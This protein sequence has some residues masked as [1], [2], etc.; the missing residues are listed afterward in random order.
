MPLS[1]LFFTELNRL[2]FRFSGRYTQECNDA[3]SGLLWANVSDLSTL[4]MTLER[5]PLPRDLSRLPEPF[6]DRRELQG[7]LTLPVLLAADPGSQILRATAIAASWFGM[8]AEYRGASFPVSSALPAH[9]NAMAVVAGGA[10]IPGLELPAFQGPTLALLP[11]PND[12]VGQI[13]VIGG[14]T[15]AEAAVAATGLAFGRATLSGTQALVE[16]AE[17][18]PRLPYDAPRWLRPDRP[19]RFGE[20]VSAE[21]LQAHGY[22]PGAVAIPVR[23]APDLYFTRARGVPVELSFRPPPGP[24]IDTSVSRLDIALSGTYLRSLPLRA[25]LPAW[26]ISEL[27]GWFGWPRERE[28]A[29][30][31][32]PPFLLSG[33]NELQLRFDMRPLNRGECGAVPGDINASIDPDSNI[34]ISGAHRFAVLPNLALFSNAGFP[35]T[36]LADL[37]ETAVV[38][39]ERPQPAEIS[40]MLDLLGR[41]AAI[42]GHPASGIM[43]TGPA[44]M[45]EVAD[46]DLILLG[47]LGRHA[48]LSQLL[49]DSAPVRLEGNRMTLALPSRLLVLGRLFPGGS[50]AVEERARATT[51]LDAPAEG[52]GALIGF[53]SPLRAGRSVVV[54]TGAAPAGVEAMAAALRDPRQQPHVQGDLAVLSGGKVESFATGSR[55]EHGA[56]PFWLWPEYYLGNRPE[57]MLLGLALACLLIG[58]PIRGALR[59]ITL[60]RLRARSP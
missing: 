17:A 7:P 53:E 27:A 55:Y 49:R 22:S 38:L 36:R 13:L 60:R 28:T 6:L 47:T 59:R 14:R 26:P 2:N 33:G 56:L 31:S 42:V 29:S 45:R 44:G 11:N 34:D 20:L 19:V 41:M 54:L 25:A 4:R 18:A 32:L 57:V 30:A 12:P 40:A 23:T 8:L 43:V 58:L 16:A 50:A 24:V 10:G 48:G 1:P 5:L 35:F 15:P 21:Q 3:L 37:S 9:G 39:P 52:F 46:R 51:R